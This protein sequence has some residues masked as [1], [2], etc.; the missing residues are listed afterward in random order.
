[1]TDKYENT[2][3]FFEKNIT[4]SEF[5]SKLVN[6]QNTKCKK[7]CCDEQLKPKSIDEGI[8]RKK[9]SV[10]TAG[11]SKKENCVKKN[12][13]NLETFTKR[14][15][16]GCCNNL[17]ERSIGSKEK[18]ALNMSLKINRSIHPLFYRK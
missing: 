12:S 7:V 18:K 3:K 16:S 5:L 2:S 9:R 1:M 11:K 15:K 14:R 13:K 6:K 8:F 17:L 4:R 10:K